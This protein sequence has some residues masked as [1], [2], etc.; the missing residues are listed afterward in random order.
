MKM[1]LSNSD[2]WDL[3]LCY[4][5]DQGSDADAVLSGDCLLVNID[6]SIDE[7]FSGDVLYNLID[8]TGA[9]INPTGVT[10]NDIGLT[11]IDNGLINY[12]CTGATSGSTFIDIFTGS[13]LFLS[14]ADTR[15]FMT[16]V[17]GCTYDYSIDILSGATEGRFAKLCGGFYQGFFKLSDETFFDEISDNKFTWPLEWFNCPWSGV[18]TGCTTGGTCCLDPNLWYE[19][20]LDTEPIPYDYQVL[21]TR[22]ERGWT[23][24]FWLKKDSN[25]CSGNGIYL[26]VKLVIQLL[27]VT[28]YHHQ[29]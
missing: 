23:S 2:Y 12:D 13:T 18:T 15:Y 29:R 20:Y 11:G 22:Y 9:T 1:R 4:D 27:L 16:R 26:V 5:C 19:D 14:T 21:P 25:G 8:W 6:I 3:F 7:S 17:T 10:L 24:I 28:H